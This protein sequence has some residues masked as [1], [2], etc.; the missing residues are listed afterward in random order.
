MRLVMLLSLFHIRNLHINLFVAVLIHSTTDPALGQAVLQLGLRTGMNYGGL[1][2][3]PRPGDIRAT[4]PNITM[5]ENCSRKED[6]GNKK[7][8]DTNSFPHL[9]GAARQLVC[10]ALLSAATDKRQRQ[11]YRCSSKAAREAAM[12]HGNTRVMQYADDDMEVSNP[13]DKNHDN[14]VDII[15]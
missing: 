2:V 12:L 1:D 15:S 10:D 4:P 14:F 7:K 8:K 9:M 11:Q 13:V 5:V 3:T 6:R